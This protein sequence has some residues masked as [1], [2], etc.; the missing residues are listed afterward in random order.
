MYIAG[1]TGIGKTTQIAQYLLETDQ[2]RRIICS[3]PSDLIASFTANR[4]ANIKNESIGEMI[5]Y[6]TSLNNR[7]NEKTILTFCSH[8]ILLKNVMQTNDSTLFS[9][10]TH[11]IVDEIQLRDTF[12]DLIL[13]LVKEILV[14]YKLI[15]FI[16]IGSSNT[17]DLFQKYFNHCPI[18]IGK[19][20]F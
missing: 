5:G 3:Q 4:I 16:L 6:Q 17:N 9:S 12:C 13:V 10:I 18:I 8:E 1:E 2:K 15:K 14:K 20:I 11:I 19:Y 7:T